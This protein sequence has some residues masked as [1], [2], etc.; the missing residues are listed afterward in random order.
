LRGGGGAAARRR[1]NGTAARG[2][3]E[4][5][6]GAAEDQ[7]LGHATQLM[8]EAPKLDAAVKNL[9]AV[10]LG[11][12]QALKL[13][14]KVHVMGE[15]GVEVRQEL[16]DLEPAKLQRLCGMLLR[17]LNAHELED[18]VAWAAR[19][20]QGEGQSGLARLDEIARYKVLHM[21]WARAREPAHGAGG[22]PARALGR[23]ALEH[24]WPAV[25]PKV[26]AELE[27]VVGPKLARGFLDEFY[28]NAQVSAPPPLGKV[29]EPD[30]DLVWAADFQAALAQR[31]QQRAATAKERAAAAA[32][33]PEPRIV[34]HGE[35]DESDD[36][37]SDEGEGEGAA[38]SSSVGDLQKM[39]KERFAYST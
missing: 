36:G 9:L 26:L 19:S 37:E 29:P 8:S 24:V 14:S 3:A 6:A 32:A 27:L 18:P 13:A 20:G 12:H 38:A 1:C 5:M 34:E 7:L 23:S 2:G 25:H 4:Q 17:H 16:E 31:S 30:Q 28:F 35:E 11:K 15:S 22:K 21:T 33:A 10:R 39:L